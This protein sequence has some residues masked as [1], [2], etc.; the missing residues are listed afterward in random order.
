[1]HTMDYTVHLI[2]IDIKFKYTLIQ[3]FFFERK[4]ECY[5][6]KN[7]LKHGKLNDIMR[8]TE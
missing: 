3:V 4:R 5:I 1:M 8:V 6:K 7:W 2:N